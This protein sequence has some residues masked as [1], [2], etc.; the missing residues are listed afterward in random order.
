MANPLVA[1]V[2]SFAGR[3]RFPQLFFLAAAIFALDLLIPDA[4]PFADE[5]VL[6][7]VTLMLGRWKKR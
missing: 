5:M 3:L 1:R 6:A 7:L 2:V 4:I